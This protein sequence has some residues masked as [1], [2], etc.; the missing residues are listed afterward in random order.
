VAGYTKFI[1]WLAQF[2]WLA[3]RGLNYGWLDGG[4]QK[5]H[6]SLLNGYTNGKRSSVVG[7]HVTFITSN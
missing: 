6:S 1:R 5:I 2:Y 3:S 4:E 7:Y